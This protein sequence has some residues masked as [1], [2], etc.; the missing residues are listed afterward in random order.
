MIAYKKISL[1]FVLMLTIF[2]SLPAG[3]ALTSPAEKSAL[4]ALYS[5]TDG[6]NWINNTNWNIGDPCNNSWYGVSCNCINGN[7]IGL[8]LTG[9]QL[10]GVIPAEIGD[11][12]SLTVLTFLYN[13]LTGS[14]PAEIGKLTSLKELTLDFNKLTGSIPAEIGDLASLEEL[15]IYTNQLIG[16]IPT[17]IGKLS[18]LTQLNLP[19]NF[20]SGEI[21]ISIDQL[22][23]NNDNGLRIENNC[24]LY[25]NDIIIQ[26]FIVL[27]SF[28]QTYEEFLA[29]QGHCITLAPVIMYLLD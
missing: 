16:A 17:E 8:D 26:N 22:P 18:N 19:N 11:L 9:N 2:T 29:T 20:L 25:S 5:S 10:T 21:P 13:Y 14:I 24:N 3:C 12:T 6:D 27:K 4:I 15:S 1:I 28:S 7:I 23:L